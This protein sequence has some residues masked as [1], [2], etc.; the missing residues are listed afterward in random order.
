M[1]DVGL[2]HGMVAESFE[3]S[4]PWDKVLNVVNN[5]KHVLKEQCIS[6]LHHII[7]P[8]TPFPSPFPDFF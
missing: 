8:L 5:T 2:D 7:Y 6:A 3:T 1:Q 4:A